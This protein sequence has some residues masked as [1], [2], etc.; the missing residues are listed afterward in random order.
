MRLSNSVRVEN[1]EE[2][3]GMK[4]LGVTQNKENLDRRRKE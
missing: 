4:E 1:D 2:K 3:T